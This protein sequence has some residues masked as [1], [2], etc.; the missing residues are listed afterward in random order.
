VPHT[1]QRPAQR[2]LEAERRPAE[3]ACPAC[4]GELAAYRVLSEGGWFDV[5]KCQGCLESV[6]REQAPPFG[7]Y[8]PLGVAIARS[9]GGTAG[10]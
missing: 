5:V 3:G 1:F 8:E 6:S 10:R 7:S 4:G 2:H 9:I